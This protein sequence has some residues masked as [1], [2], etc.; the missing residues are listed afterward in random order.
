MS[1]LQYTHKEMVKLCDEA[2]R[3]MISE[4]QSM[5][6]DLGRD[7]SGECVWVDEIEGGLVDI[8]ENSGLTDKV[9]EL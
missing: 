7:V 6:A 5:L 9:N 2:K 3:M 1:E 4:F 8:K